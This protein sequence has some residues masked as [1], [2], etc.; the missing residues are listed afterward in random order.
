MITRFDRAAVKHLR[1][2]IESALE[3]IAQESGVQFTVGRATFDHTSTK[4]ALTACVMDSEGQ[5]LTQERTDFV[6]LAKYHA[7]DPTDLDRKVVAFGATYR[8]AGFR[9]KAQKN[10]VLMEREDGKMFV[11]PAATVAEYIKMRAFLR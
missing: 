10:N 2:R 3:G 9:R 1:E 6:A 4:F 11:M 7:L 5:P 8:I